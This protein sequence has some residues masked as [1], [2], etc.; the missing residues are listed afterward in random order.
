MEVAGLVLGALPIAI[1]AVEKY[2]KPIESYKNYSQTLKEIRRNLFVQEQQLQVTLEGI[3]LL[4]P[5]LP[6]VQQKLRE[7]NPEC[8]AQFIDILE[9]MDN[10]TSR[11]MDKLEIDSD[12]KP[13]WT[14]ETPERVSWE[15]RR[16]KR[17]FGDKYRKE[18]FDELQHWN[19]ALKNCLEPKRE[20][21]S[22][23]ADLMTAEPVRLFDLKSCDEAREN[24]RI[25]HEALVAAWSKCTCHQHPSN[26]E[27]IWQH[28]GLKE[29]GQ[30][31]LSVPELG[32]NGRDKHWQKVS[33]SIDPNRMNS[34]SD[35][36]AAPSLSSTTKLAPDST[37][38]VPRKRKPRP[39]DGLRGILSLKLRPRKKPV[40]SQIPVTS[41]QLETLGRSQNGPLDSQLIK[42]L[43]NL[44]Q[45]KDWN[46]HL[47]HTGTT[48][49]KVIY[50]KRV[51]SPCSRFS[52]RSLESVISNSYNAG[53]KGKQVANVRLSRKERLG[54]AAAAV[55]AVLILCGTPWLEERWLGKE[56][57]T[58]LVDI[59]A[60]G[61]GFDRPKIYPSLSHIFT[62]QQETSNKLPRNQYSDNHQ[63]FQTRHKTLFTLGILLIELGLNKAFHQIR[64]DTNTG[65]PIHETS[66]QDDYITAKQVIDSEELELELGE[67]YANA[68][69]RCIQCHFL[70]PESTQSFLHS[71]FRKQFFTGV[72]AP[73]QA[74]FDAQIT[75]VNSL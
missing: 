65:G 1:L 35:C 59:P 70:G 40:S 68:V 53:S 57:I 71:R 18:L 23:H 62:S 20:I 50:M 2:L 55:W 25:V 56:D 14:D 13:K 54:I 27:L 26:V 9:H 3:G 4:K 31:G 36:N 47:L 58:L 49:K 46:G 38:V 8:S 74:T 10:M 69:Q 29:T 60:Q 34:A 41:L 19:T 33:I 12:G 45:Q 73:V 7:V 61:N 66:V 37:S 32:G 11:L 21:P 43:C 75:S 52:S 72:V 15:W 48:N 67:S 44:I 6:E 24:V 39:T 28:A 22:D 64:A 30:L 63:Q 16:V 17:S 5:T 51:L 42:G